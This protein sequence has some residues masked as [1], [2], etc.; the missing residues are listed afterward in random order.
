MYQGKPHVI[1]NKIYSLNSRSYWEKDTSR[2][3]ASLSVINHTLELSSVIENKTSPIQ[4]P[5]KDSRGRGSH[6]CQELK[7]EQELSG[8][9]VGGKV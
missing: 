3:V 6:L 2:L 8:L 9:H 5:W 4:R 1:R 7:I